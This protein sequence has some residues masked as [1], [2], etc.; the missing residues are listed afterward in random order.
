MLKHGRV[1]ILGACLAL[2]LFA[3]TWVSATPVATSFFTSTPY[4]FDGTATYL[5]AGATATAYA[6]TNMDSSVPFP[7]Q[8]PIDPIEITATAIVVD[9]TQKS[10]DMTA[11]ANPIDPIYVTSTY[12]VG[13]ATQIQ[14]FYMTATAWDTIQTPLP[15]LTLTSTLSDLDKENLRTGWRADLEKATGFSDPL[16]DNV[17]Q[18]LLDLLSWEYSVADLGSHLSIDVER[19]NY[20]GDDYIAII[21]HSL[22]SVYFDEFWMF[23]V[24]DDVPRIVLTSREIRSSGILNFSWV[25]DGHYLGGFEDRNA[26]GQPDLAIYTNGGGSC[27]SSQIRIVEIASNGELSDLSPNIGASVTNLVDVNNDGMPEIQA[28]W[29]ASDIPLAI[30]TCYIYLVRYY[31]WDGTAYQDISPTLDESLWP[32]VGQ[33]FKNIQSRD[34]CLFPDY[35]DI[36]IYE[37]LLAYQGMGRLEEGWQSLQPQLRWDKCSPEILAKRGEDMGKFLAWVG[38]HLQEEQQNQSISSS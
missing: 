27:D 33:F 29:S 23:R 37:L 34:G 19:R 12:I 36:S 20:Q 14:S 1:L 16:L 2:A 18:D 32:V 7:T 13:R 21:V 24:H 10:Y 4:D 35:T 22:H 28:G 38:K 11:T 25:I 26:N 3:G 17:T 8:T 31:G 9:A 15:T 6:R 30:K 5:V